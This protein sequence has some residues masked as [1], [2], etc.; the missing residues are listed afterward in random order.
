[1]T[2]GHHDAVVVSKVSSL[3]PVLQS[4]P[5]CGL[6]ALSMASQLLPRDGHPVSVEALFEAAKSLQF[7]KKGE[8]FSAGH[9]KTLAETLP[10]RL[11]SRL[12]S[13]SPQSRGRQPLDLGKPVLV[14]YDSDGN[15]EPCLKSG[16]TA[17]WAVLHGICLVVE[18]SC[19]LEPPLESLLEQDC[20]CERL[21][22]VKDGLPAS[23]SPRE[24]LLPLALG[25]AD[26]AVFVCGSQGK[27]RH[28]G[29]WGLDRLLDSNRN[30]A[31]VGPRH[32]AAEFVMPAGGVAEGLAGMVDRLLAGMPN[33]ASDVLLLFTCGNGVQNGYLVFKSQ[34]LSFLTEA[35]ILTTAHFLDARTQEPTRTRE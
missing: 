23:G 16:H 34:C 28:V 19:L 18:S 35:L 20:E 3:K 5:Q 26:A 13:R 15:F 29:L 11:P 14:P 7:T 25:G 24:L 8:M 32:E 6:V 17:H 2:A 4:G 30:L 22:H 10:G 12:R 9:M 27:S 31:H 33:L 1:M 21:Y